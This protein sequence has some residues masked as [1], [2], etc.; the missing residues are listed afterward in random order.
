M[1]VASWRVLVVVTLFAAS[2]VAAAAA[3]PA[4]SVK[5][6][7]G[8]TLG[9]EVMEQVLG[10]GSREG[11]ERTRSSNTSTV[12][13]SRGKRALMGFPP[14]S[15][16]AFFFRLFIPFWSY[17][18]VRMTGDFRVE[19]TYKLP[20]NF[21]RRKRSLV[22]ERSTLYSL[23]GDFLSKAG[24]DGE[25]CILRAVCDVGEAPLD[26]YGLL[27]EIITLIFAPGFEGNNLH[28]DFMQAE[29]YG[30]SYGNCWSA[31]PNCPMSMR[32]MLHEFFLNNAQFLT[33]DGT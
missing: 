22:N 1:E 28:K 18:R 20:T 11:R 5:S 4:S 24:L 33:E 8:T 32:E 27:G 10:W 14:K 31:F 9:P 15:I 3:S 17:P 25:E 26:E 30:R 16:V 29:E 21:F 12:G 6:L 13:R 23:L 7:L 19:V 2:H